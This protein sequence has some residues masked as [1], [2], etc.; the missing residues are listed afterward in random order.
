MRQTSNKRD[1]IVEAGAL[2]SHLTQFGA[3][4]KPIVGAKIHPDIRALGLLYEEFIIVGG[5]ARC[6][7]MLNVFKKVPVPFFF[8]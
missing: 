4:K 2:F 8:N 7:A 6:L 5:N 1:P 3:K